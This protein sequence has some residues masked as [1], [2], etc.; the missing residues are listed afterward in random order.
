M[1]TYRIHPGIG[2]ARLG[3]SDSEFYLAQEPPAVGNGTKIQAASEVA[4]EDL[5]HLLL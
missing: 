2:I 4:S 3:N 5:L 1:A